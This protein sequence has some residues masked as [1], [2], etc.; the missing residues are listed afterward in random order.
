[1]N[2]FIKIQL[3]F[4]LFT[5][6]SS[7]AIADGSPVNVSISASLQPSHWEGE[8]L[9]GGTTFESDATQTQLALNISKGK[10]Y[11]GLSF[12]GAEYDFSGGAPNKV[13]KTTSV[14]DD[15]ATI[16]RGEFDLV[17]GYYFLPQIS[18]FI[19]FKTI[20]NN[21]KNDPYSLRYKGAGFGANGHYPINKD[22]VAI[23]S[24]GFMRLDI[25]ANGES[26]GDGRGSALS[27]GALYR[28]NPQANFSIRLKA[29]HN[30]YDF[31]EGSEQDHDIGGLV[32]GFGYAIQ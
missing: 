28:I 9:N 19:D 1:M 13:S 4:V 27:V 24:I 2:K 21:W 3:F 16:Q 8:N 23:G 22:W 17:F 15:D 30:E 11:G 6:F 14:Q 26:I 32:F 7:L 29:Q 10:F 18:F 5:G 20:E 31:D 12:Q 25:K